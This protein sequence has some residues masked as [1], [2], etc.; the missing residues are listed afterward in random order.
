MSHWEDYLVCHFG[1]YMKMPPVTTRKSHHY[2]YEYSLGKYADIPV[3]ELERMVLGK[4][5][6]TG[7]DSK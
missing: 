6:N 3:E 2:V 1:D 5:K 7:E 4:P